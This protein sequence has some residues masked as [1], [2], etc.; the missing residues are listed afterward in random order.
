ML[1]Q[2]SSCVT[3]L[4]MQYPQHQL[5]IQS[6][7]LTTGSSTDPIHSDYNMDRSKNDGFLHQWNRFSNM[8]STSEDTL[9]IVTNVVLKNLTPSDSNKMPQTSIE[10]TDF[11]VSLTLAMI[12]IFGV[13]GNVMNIVVL[14]RRRFISRFSHLLCSFNYGLIALAV[15]NL[16]VCLVVIPRGFLLDTRLLV[17]EDQ[18]LTLFYKVYGV[19]VINL[20]MMVSMWQVVSMVVHRCM[21]VVYPLQVR[22]I[23]TKIQAIKT[24]AIITLLSMILTA[25]HFLLLKIQSCYIYEE[26]LNYE[27]RLLLSWGHYLQFYIRWIWPVLAVFLPAIILLVCICRL[28]KDLYN[29][30]RR[31]KKLLTESCNSYEF[32][33]RRRHR[34]PQSSKVKMNKTLVAVVLVVM[35]LVAPVEIIR[36]INPYQVWGTKTG[37]IISLIGNFLQTVGFASNFILYCVVNSKFRKTLKDLCCVFRYRSETNVLKD[38]DHMHSDV[39]YIVTKL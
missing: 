19:A 17:E 20:F 28:A 5:F 2:R 35:F 36:Y 37:H 31:Q 25:P 3:I 4:L 1:P 16:L 30:F 27:V 9:N 7:G 39:T 34:K 33:T 26:G 6:L 18:W 22:T 15:S 29:A 11:R 24:I 13:F 10:Q 32:F 8:C 23:F 12:G 14:T 38:Y 21:V